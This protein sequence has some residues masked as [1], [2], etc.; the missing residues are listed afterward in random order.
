MNEREMRLYQQ[1]IAKHHTIYPCRQKKTFQE[2]FTISGGRLLFWYN[3]ED[4][5]THI[6]IDEVG[7]AV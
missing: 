3:T 2:C 6:M 1:A 4:H 5:S 7:V